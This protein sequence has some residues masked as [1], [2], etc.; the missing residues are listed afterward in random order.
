MSRLRLSLTLLIV[1]LALSFLNN[2]GQHSPQRYLARSPFRL[3]VAPGL[4]V[5][6]SQGNNDTLH[7]HVGKAKWAFD[8]TVS[9]TNFVVTAAQGGM[10]IGA[11]DSSTTGCGDVGC[12]TEANYVLIADDD[13]THS[14]QQHPFA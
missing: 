3:P 13:G 5:F 7:D 10:V 8:F 6:V 4:T 14:K 2:S 9:T 12:W 1:L 11:D